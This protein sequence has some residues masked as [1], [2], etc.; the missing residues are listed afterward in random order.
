MR[1]IQVPTPT[2]EGHRIYEFTKE[3]RVIPREHFFENLESESKTNGN[4]VKKLPIR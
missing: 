4:I 1:D 3:M 2:G